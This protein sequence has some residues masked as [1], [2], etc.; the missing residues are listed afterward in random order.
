MA[1]I[2]IPGEKF[3]ICVF[4]RLRMMD[5]NLLELPYKQT[6][7]LSNH[8]S[9]SSNIIGCLVDSK[10]VSEEV[11]LKEKHVKELCFLPKSDLT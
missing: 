4:L 2:V 1:S 3:E 11:R 8:I 5:G 10:N 6:S 9:Y 7:I